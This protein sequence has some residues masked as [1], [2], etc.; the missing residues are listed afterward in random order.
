MRCIVCKVLLSIGLAV[1]STAAT[2]AAEEQLKP[3]PVEGGKAALT[4]ENTTIQFVGTHVGEKPDPRTGHFAK[5]AGQ[6]RLGADA[7]SLEAVDVTIDTASLITDIDRL[8]NH[9][10]SPDFFDVR[11]FPKATFKSTEVQPTDVAGQFE[12][13][14]ELTLHGETQKISFPAKLERI[15]DGVVLTSEFTVER[16]KFAMNFGPDRV[17]N[18]VTITVKVGQ[19]TTKGA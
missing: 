11:S 17:A 10:K 9:L 18:E 5:F 1:A 19:P 13:T 16:D 12:V 7:K 8:T 4:A 2:W 6:I 15:A 14:G 3:V